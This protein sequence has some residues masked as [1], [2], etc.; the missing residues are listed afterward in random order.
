MDTFDFTM[1]LY[2]SRRK[3]RSS[4]LLNFRDFNGGICQSKLS[5]PKITKQKTRIKSDL[6]ARGFVAGG[7]L[8]AGA[9]IL[10]IT[11][12]LCTGGLL[13]LFVITA[14]A[15][16]AACCSQQ[17]KEDSKEIPPPKDDEV[18]KFAANAMQR[19][20][21]GFKMTQE[22]IEYDGDIIFDGSSIRRIDEFRIDK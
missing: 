4:D 17:A 8:G 9:G 1:G 19:G 22:K 20:K 5:A 21:G 11:G 12:S 10:C 14:G 15:V 3:K 2:E 7:I 18:R 16:G 13:P 6:P